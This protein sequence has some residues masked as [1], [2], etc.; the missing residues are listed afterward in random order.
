MRKI[1]ASGVWPLAIKEKTI[2]ARIEVL[3]TDSLYFDKDNVRFK[4]LPNEMSQEAIFHH[5]LKVEAIGPLKK[6]I[7]DNGGI[8]EPLIVDKRS[9][10]NIVKEGNR[11]LA[12]LRLLQTEARDAEIEGHTDYPKDQFDFTQCAILPNDITEE[13][14]AIYLAQVHVQG[15]LPW[16]PQNKAWL[17]FWMDGGGLNLSRDQIAKN[18]SMSKT[19]V[20]NMISAYLYTKQYG[21]TFND[22]LW[23]EKFSY[24]AEIYKKRK[25]I[26]AKYV[27]KE[28]IYEKL[29][30]EYLYWFGQ[31]IKEGKLTRGEDV[32]KLVKFYE[33]ND[34]QSLAE[35]ERTDM[36]K[37]WRLHENLFPEAG[38]PIYDAIDQ[39]TMALSSIKLSEFEQLQED[40]ARLAKLKA[41]RSSIDSILVFA[42]G[43]ARVREA[44]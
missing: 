31:L 27:S 14:L 42:E 18:F 6:G 23:L 25:K 12:C 22:K 9:G 37:A 13:E 8:I 40:D 34:E 15:K 2:P 41:L 28:G 1:N 33:T 44:Q 26:P 30:D 10:K 20:Q 43:T 36:K 11:R 19:S 39:A 3:K 7:A 32:R 5:L 21:E 24:F 29:T 4:H 17:V 38:N 35:L 16:D